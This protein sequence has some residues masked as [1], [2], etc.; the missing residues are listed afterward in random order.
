MIRMRSFITLLAAML[1]AGLAM[2]Q[3]PDIPVP[4]TST[5]AEA[6]ASRLEEIM[7]R[8]RGQRPAAALSGGYYRPPADA[9][10]AG[11]TAEDQLRQLGGNSDADIWRQ[12]RGG[13]QATPSSSTATGQLIQVLGDDWRVLRR[14][15]ILKYTGWILLGVLLA[16]AL[17]YVIRGR[18]RI[19]DGRSGKTIKRFSMSHRIAHWFLASVFILMAI[20]GLLILLGRPVLMPLIGRD[21]MSALASASLQGHNLFGPVFILALLIVTFRFMRGNFFQWADFKWI[22]KG[23]GLLGGHA[24]SNHYNFG[25]KGWYWMVVLVGLM[26][27]VTG[28]LLLFPGLIPNLAVFQLSTILHALG[29]VTLISVALAHAYI[30]SIGMEGSLDSMLRG[31]VDENWAKEHHDLWYQQVTGN[32]VDHADETTDE[33]PAKAEGAT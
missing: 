3:T 32:K 21:V 25:E 4:G 8:Q 28:I 12:I 5:A 23:G 33:T 11:T 6:A 13:V 26:M 30:G 10:T 24:S 17:F 9:A 27:S 1:W 19:R 2:A 29:A 20:S 18:I 31:E 14:D 22:L 16:L 15:Y 7:A